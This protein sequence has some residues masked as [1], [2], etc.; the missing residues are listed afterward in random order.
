MEIV[1]SRES[2]HCRDILRTVLGVGQYEPYRYLVGYV[3]TLAGD[4]KA[5]CG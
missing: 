2:P 5:G 4:V 1:R 3:V